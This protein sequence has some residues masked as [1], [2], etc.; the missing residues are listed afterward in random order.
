MMESFGELRRE[1][2]KSQEEKIKIGDLVVLKKDLNTLGSKKFGIV[3]EIDREDIT[4]VW[5]KIMWSVGKIT[6]EDV[7]IQNKLNIDPIYRIISL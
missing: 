7:I 2:Y 1:T 5:A 3:L 6:W 4:M